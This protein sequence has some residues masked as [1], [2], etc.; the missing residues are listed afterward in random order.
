[1]KASTRRSDVAAAPVHVLPELPYA[2]AAL[3]PCIDERTMMLH[4]GKHHAGYVDKLNELLSS[5][6]ELR[7]RSPGWL[8]VNSDAIPAE[9]RAD[10]LHNAGGHLNHSLLWRAM[11]PLGGAGPTGALAAAIDAS[12]GSVQ[13]FQTRFE[14][15]GAKVFGS[16]WVW[17]VMAAGARGRS[18]KLEVVTT[19]GHDNPIQHGQRA[20]LVNDVWEHAYYLHYENRRPEYLRSWWR[21]AN[22]NEAVHRF[23]RPDDPSDIEPADG[24]LPRHS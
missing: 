10:V 2:C 22:W 11:S 1:M 15:A 18:A 8:L 3:E 17:L 5:H 24:L 23:E 7:M 9:I 12:F 4:H 19:S 14:E 13:Q 16:G 20:L 21:I 6:R